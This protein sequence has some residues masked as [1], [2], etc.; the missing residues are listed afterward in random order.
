MADKQEPSL[1]LPSF[2]LRRRKRTAAG[3]ETVASHPPHPVGRFRIP[4]VPRQVAVTVT[5]VLVGLLAVGLTWLLLRFCEVV[6]GTSSCGG[7]PGLL[8]L[9]L[10]LATLAVV[11]AGML[12]AFGVP[13]PGSTS[14][15][16]VGLVAVLALLFLVDVL[17]ARWMVLVIP[18]LTALAFVLAHAVTTAASDD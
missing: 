14:V 3:F 9:L 2:S 10:A 7:G 4:T 16:A 15:L 17:L 11:G 5:G 13:Q 12:R 6:S 1:E 8:L 18:A